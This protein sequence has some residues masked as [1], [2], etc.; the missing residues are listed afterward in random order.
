MGHKTFISYKFSEAQGVRDDIIGALGKDAQYYQGETSDSPD[1]TDTTTENIKKS[2]ADML[3]DTSVTIVVISPHMIESKWI[4]WEIQYSLCEYSRGGVTS[5]TNGVLG[6]IM[7]VNG[8]YDWFVRKT[9]NPDGCQ[10]MSYKLEYLPKII[11]DNRDN[12]VPKQYSCQRCK[13]IDMLTGNFISLITLSDFLAT[14]SLYI[15]NAYK[16]AYKNI[17]NYEINKGF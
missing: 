2:L 9:I 10:T 3:Y 6:V 17:D 12:Q 13:C 7:E 14:P 4:P 15:E 16:K 8:G 5:K 1:L 11:K